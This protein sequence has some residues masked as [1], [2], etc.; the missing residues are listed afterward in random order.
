MKKLVSAL[1]VVVFA[2]GA[3]ALAYASIPDENGVIH[4]CFKNESG[5]LRVI[6]GGDCHPNESALDWNQTGPPG[7]LSGY[8]IITSDP[9][10][11]DP[12]G[13]GQAQVTCPQGTRATGGGYIADPTVQVTNVIPAGAGTVWSAAGTNTSDSQTAILRARAICANAGA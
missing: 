6:E 7:G 4:G 8:Q 1:A 12:G 9:V 10:T 3:A 13:H 2:A 5:Q 11:L